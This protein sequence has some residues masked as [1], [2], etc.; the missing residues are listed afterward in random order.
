MLRSG[1]R[2]LSGLVSVFMHARCTPPPGWP[3][4]VR[5][6]PEPA[7]PPCGRHA[8]EMVKTEGFWRV[9]QVSNA[10]WPGIRAESRARLVAGGGVLA[11]DIPDWCLATCRTDVS[12]DP[13][14]SG[15]PPR[16]CGHVT[17]PFA[18]HRCGGREASC[19]PCR[20]PVRRLEVL[21]L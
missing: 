5:W 17:Y 12:G 13:G 14:L 19:S 8:Y 3:G 21:A 6:R 7:R 20:R 2:T 10:F 4:T 9:G 1:S 16:A 15:C 18:D 11:Q